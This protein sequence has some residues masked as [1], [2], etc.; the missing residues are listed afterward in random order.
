M[1]DSVG[2]GEFYQEGDDTKQVDVGVKDSELHED[3]PRVFV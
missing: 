3:G 2:L 1:C